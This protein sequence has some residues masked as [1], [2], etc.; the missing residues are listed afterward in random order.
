MYIYARSLP[1]SLLCL[2]ATGGS[3]W[4]DLLLLFFSFNFYEYF[5]GNCLPNSI[6][7]KLIIKKIMKLVKNL[8]LTV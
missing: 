5:C 3:G 2:E 1:L 7:D 8:L 4:M 6:K